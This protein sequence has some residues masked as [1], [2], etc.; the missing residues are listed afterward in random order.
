MNSKQI[1]RNVFTSETTTFF[2]INNLA[3]SWKKIVDNS[4]V[5]MRFGIFYLINE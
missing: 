4:L 2:L 1:S 5:E 3:R